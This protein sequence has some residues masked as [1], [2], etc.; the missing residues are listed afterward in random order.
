MDAALEESNMLEEGE[1]LRTI[2]V[3]MNMHYLTDRLPRPN[4]KP[5]ST[6]RSYDA[7]KRSKYSEEDSIM[8]EA[9]R[10]RSLEVKAKPKGKA[11]LK[12]RAAVEKRLPQEERV[13]AEER[14]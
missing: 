8:G 7:E 12:G 3:P 5:L 10:G 4:Y 11:C 2:K 6:R 9:D 1:L 14:Q 13:Q